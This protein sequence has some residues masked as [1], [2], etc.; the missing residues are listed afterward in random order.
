MA[1]A[2]TGPMPFKVLLVEAGQAEL[3]QGGRRTRLAAGSFSLLDGAEP[4]ELSASQGFVHLVAA[5]P[6]AAVLP[7]HRGL[8]RGTAIGHDALGAASLV[9]D[10]VRSWARH[11]DKRAAP[12][13]HHAA[14]AALVN[15]LGALSSSAVHD[16]DESLRVRAWA[17]IEL[18]LCEVNAEDLARQ[19]N[20]SRRHLDAVFARSGAPLGEQLWERRL[21]LAAQRLCAPGQTSITEIAHGVGFKDASHFAKAFRRRFLCTPSQWRARGQVLC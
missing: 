4:F 16:S 12:S 6:R 7:R 8:E 21:T 1:P 2:P 10:L 19:L 20:V 17:K 18:D 11:G 5:V 13:L 15:L 3:S 9:G 14:A